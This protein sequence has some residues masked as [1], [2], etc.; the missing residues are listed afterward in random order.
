MI[1]AHPTGPAALASLVVEEA[2]ARRA[3]VR[4]IDERAKQRIL[5]LG[6]AW[7]ESVD[8]RIA[9]SRSRVP[10][11]RTALLLDAAASQVRA[12]RLA[13]R[14][15]IVPPI[16]RTRPW[17]DVDGT[18]LDLAGAFTAPVTWARSDA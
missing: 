16:A 10:E 7:A 17:L 3:R 5:E 6:V 15:G 12:R 1:A 4:P 9:A 11:E 8:A 14:L 13:I 18:D 2:T